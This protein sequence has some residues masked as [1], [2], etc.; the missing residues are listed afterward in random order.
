MDRHAFRPQRGKHTRDEPG[1]GRPVYEQGLECVAHAGALHLCVAHDVDSSQLV[2]GFVEEDMDDPGPGLDDGHC[3]LGDDRGDELCAAARD[4]HVNEAAGLHEF[5]GAGPAECVDGLHA[6]ARKADG[7]DCGLDQ[8]DEHPVRIL[9]CTTSA[10]HDRVP[11]LE[12]KRGEVDCDV[13]PGL[14]DDPNDPEWNTDLAEAQAILQGGAPHG[15]PHRVD[16]RGDLANRNGKPVQ[17]RVVETQTILQPGAQPVLPAIGEIEVVRFEDAG[18]AALQGERDRLKGVV[19]LLGA[20]HG[21]RPGSIPRREQR[22][23]DGCRN[24]C[25][26]RHDSILAR[27]RAAR[28]R[29]QHQTRCRARLRRE[30]MRPVRSR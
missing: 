3:R 20:R 25:R 12:C 24:R 28:P 15:L 19:L 16:E 29:G 6:E 4:E 21:E 11:T 7:L 18:S 10:Q 26:V 1:G 17:P 8:V 9:G 22:V 14:V 23:I 5:P 13:R 2:G 27:T 30:R